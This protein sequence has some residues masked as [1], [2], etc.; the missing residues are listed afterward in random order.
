MRK[1]EENGEAEEK[2]LFVATVGNFLQLFEWN[3]VKI[4]QELGYEVHYAANFDDILCKA[5]VS[6]LEACEFGHIVFRFA[7]LRG[8]FLKMFAH[9]DSYGV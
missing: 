8:C 1:A 2:V 5:D 9:T 7:V 3:D 4:L 6:E